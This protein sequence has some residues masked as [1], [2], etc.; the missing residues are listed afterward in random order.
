VCL[1]DSEFGQDL[2]GGIEMAAGKRRHRGGKE[3]AV[4]SSG[5]ERIEDAI[6][7]SLAAVGRGRSEPLKLLC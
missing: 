2:V 6:P 4:K 7:A 1:L 5:G 3:E